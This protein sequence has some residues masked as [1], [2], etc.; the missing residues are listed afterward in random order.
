MVKLNN[1]KIGVGLMHPITIIEILLALGIVAVLLVIAFLLPR[2]IR[3][4]A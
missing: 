4:S 3:K 1:L 2:N